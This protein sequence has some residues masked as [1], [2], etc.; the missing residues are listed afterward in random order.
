MLKDLGDV[1]SS[2]WVASQSLFFVVWEKSLD[3]ITDVGWS[4]MW[5]ENTGKKLSQVMNHLFTDPTRLDFHM[6]LQSHLSITPAASK[7]V[8]ATAQGV[9]LCAES[10]HFTSIL[11][12]WNGGPEFHPNQISLWSSDYAH[13]GHFAAAL[14]KTPSVAPVWSPGV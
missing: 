9:G 12:A 2:D 14:N 5:V 11:G 8:T 13:G 10:H 6:A 7:G 3:L 4:P 1:L